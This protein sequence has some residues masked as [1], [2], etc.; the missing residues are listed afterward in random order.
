MA[1]EV[2]VGEA[3]EVVGIVDGDLP[4]VVL[5]GAAEGHAELRH[6]VG[7]GADAIA[8]GLV[9]VNARETVAEEGAIEVV[10]RGCV[11][12]GVR[13]G[14]VECGEGLVDVAVEAEGYALGADYLR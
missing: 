7:E 6:G 1:G 14:C 9:F 11:G 12:G 13:D 3:E 2:V 4:N 8:G 10:E 5:D